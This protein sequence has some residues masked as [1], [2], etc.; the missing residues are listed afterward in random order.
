MVVDKTIRSTCTL[1]G[2]VHVNASKRAA[3]VVSYIES[4]PEILGQVQVAIIHIMRF[5]LEIESIGVSALICLICPSSRDITEHVARFELT[6]DIFKSDAV[7]FLNEILP[8]AGQLRV[9]W[10][11]CAQGTPRLQ[12]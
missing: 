10:Y 3:E 1:V 12:A 6:C 9:V 2:I 4:S 5:T 7:D 11:R 8:L